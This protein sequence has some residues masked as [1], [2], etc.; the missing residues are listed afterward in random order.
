M[1]IAELVLKYVEALVWPLVTVALVYGL[2]AHIKDAFG[3]LTRLETPA[4]SLE[5]AVEARELRDEAAELSVTLT[6]GVVTDRH[7]PPTHPSGYPVPEPV[8]VADAEPDTALD[9]GV[10]PPPPP[11]PL[12]DLEWEGVP[13]GPPSHDPAEEPQAPRWRAAPPPPPPGAA[14]TTPRPGDEVTRQ[15]HRPI[16]SHFTDDL[17]TGPLGMTGESP[18]E[19][20]ITAWSALERIAADVL[21]QHSLPAQRRAAGPYDIRQLVTGLRA[22]GLSDDAEVVVDRLR[23]LRDT[24][25]HHPESVSAGAAQDFVMACL[26]LARDIQAFQLPRPY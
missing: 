26:T 9:R 2:R 22:L 15:R 6:P 17:F 18:A 12:A 8:P 5:F 10:P 13:A 25:V 1:E 24:A 14:S 3:R 11:W 21:L 16:G 4:G 20:V 19:A 7:R 23:R